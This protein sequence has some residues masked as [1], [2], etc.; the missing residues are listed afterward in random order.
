MDRRAVGIAALLGGMLCWGITPVLLRGL[1]PFIDAWTANGLRYPL[2]AILYWPLLWKLYRSGELTSS[3]VKCCLVPA[4]LSAGGQIFWALAHYELQAS[5]I[6]FFVR[7]STAWAILGSMYLFADER[8]LLTQPRFYAGLAIIVA[9]FLLMS[10]IPEKSASTMAPTVIDGSLRNGNYTLGVVYALLS[11]SF[12]GLYLASIRWFIP[13]VH[14][15]RAFSI[16]AQMVSVVMLCL[17]M[18]LGDPTSIYRQTAF[19]WSL[20]IGSSIMGISI[21]H[22]LAYTAVQRLG[23]A[24]TSSCQSVLPFITAAAAGITLSETLLRQQWMGGVTMIVGA[25]LLLSIRHQISQPQQRDAD[26]KIE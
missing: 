21:G 15:M 18:I 26:A 4:L 13:N 8:H 23:A 7:T 16:V 20:L 5:E 2:A 3:L 9:G 24:I 6:G 19:S 10:L 12:F 17:M 14:P 1:T 22:V 11:S 25:G